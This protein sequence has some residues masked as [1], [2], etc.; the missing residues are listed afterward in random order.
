MAQWI[1]PFLL[2][3]LGSAHC[4]GMC[5]GF[6]AAI[7]A[8]RQP[9]WPALARQLVYSAGRVFTYAFLGAVGGFIGIYLSQYGTTL[10]S[11]QRVF[12]MLA[13]LIMILVGASVLGLFRLGWFRSIGLSELAAPMFARFLNTRGWGGFFLAGLAN[14]FL[15]CGLVYAILAT[16]VAAQDMGKGAIIMVAFGTGTIPAM[17]AIGCGAMLLGRAV[18]ERIFKVAACLVLAM[19]V[20]TIARAWP[21]SESCC[22]HE[23]PGIVNNAPPPG[24]QP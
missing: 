15:P 4:I 18:R 10:V 20:V 6:A 1:A 14:G 12:S 7:G 23:L 19:G 3:L 9:L 11:A 5:G 8:T 24:M 2:G 17:V 22:D 16:A 13:G 21:T